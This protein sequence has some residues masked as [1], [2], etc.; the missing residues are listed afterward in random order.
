M[1]CNDWAYIIIFANS[2]NIIEGHWTSWM[3]FQNDPRW[4]GLATGNLFAWFV[5]A[6]RQSLSHLLSSILLTV[7]L[8]GE[9]RVQ[10]AQKI[11]QAQEDSEILHHATQLLILFYTQYARYDR[12][13]IMKHQS[14]S[15]IS[16]LNLCIT[17][18]K[19]QNDRGLT[20]FAN[21]LS[22]NHKFWPH[23]IG[24]YNNFIDL[25]Y[26]IKILCYMCHGQKSLYRGWSS[27]LL[28]GILIMGPYKPL[29][30]WV[31]FSHPLLYANNRSWST[32]SHIY[33]VIS[34]RNHCLRTVE[35]DL[36]FLCLLGHGMLRKH[37]WGGLWSTRHFF[38]WGG[39]H[40]GLLVMSMD[41]CL[42]A[43]FKMNNATKFMR[44]VFRDLLNH[45]IQTPCREPDND[46]Y[47]NGHQVW[48]QA[49]SSSGTNRERGCLTHG[50]ESLARLAPMATSLYHK[51]V[52]FGSGT[53]RIVD[54]WN[55]MT[56]FDNHD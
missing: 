41:M 38:F 45:S 16:S 53:V 4:L 32:R 9:L 22:E 40:P 44:I 6:S 20:S 8:V 18:Q 19:L 39:V 3:F 2:S 47:V 28:I 5:G 46:G 26:Y 36:I 15:S 21:V 17:S 50:W 31:D 29:R 52:R 23:L 35:L 13:I 51:C 56:T 10:E 11:H 42:G 14:I 37:C 49:A 30:T 1:Q 24:T 48:A 33:V 34:L 12:N 55:G 43:L 54:D 25:V 27:H 7:R